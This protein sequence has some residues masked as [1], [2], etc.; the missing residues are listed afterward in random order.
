MRFENNPHRTL[1]MII[2]ANPD[3][4]PVYLCKVGLDDVYMRLWVRMEDVSLVTF[5]STKNNPTDSQLVGFHLYLHMI[6]I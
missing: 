4:G 3:L 2:N 1:R 6:Y 5:L